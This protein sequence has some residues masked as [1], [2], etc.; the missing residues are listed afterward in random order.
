MFINCLEILLLA[1]MSLQS[2]L[3]LFTRQYISGNDI[4]VHCS[5]IH[6]EIK[7]VN[8]IK[9]FDFRVLKCCSFN[10]KHFISAGIY[11]HALGN[12]LVHTVEINDSLNHFVLILMNFSVASKLMKK[13][14][15]TDLWVYCLLYTHI[16]IL[17]LETENFLLIQ[18]TFLIFALA[19]TSSMI[20]FLLLCFSAI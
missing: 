13:N 16:A 10:L 5:S 20:S 7:T 6:Q 11:S 12:I 18:L 1:L 17:V 4:T 15:K 2:N 8:L 9:Y 14:V 19:T 3:I